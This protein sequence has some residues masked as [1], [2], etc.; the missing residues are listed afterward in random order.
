MLKIRTYFQISHRV[1]N[2]MQR[3]V[4]WVVFVFFFF[5]IKGMFRITK[6]I[7][8]AWNATELPLVS[9]CKMLQLLTS[10]A[11]LYLKNGV[12]KNIAA[13]FDSFFFIEFKSI[14]HTHTSKL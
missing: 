7:T 14:K 11:S 6:A 9:S 2:Y 1:F 13:Q 4:F 10:N 12:M 3:L 8:K 5:F